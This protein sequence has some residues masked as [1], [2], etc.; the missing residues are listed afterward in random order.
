MTI[1]IGQD[2]SAFV[3]P[4]HAQVFAQAAEEFNCH[5]LVRE[6]GR[7]A[8][9]WIQRNGYT[10]KIADMKANTAD[11]NPHPYTLAGLVCCPLLVPQAFSPK[12][13]IRAQENW[14]KSA[15]L[16]TV[17]TD[18]AGF[19]DKRAPSRCKTPYLVQT[20]PRHKHYGAV[21]RV[22]MG[23]L[24]PRYVHG[25]YD[26]YAIVPAG[27]RFDPARVRTKESQLGISMN[28]HKMTFGQ[29]VAEEPR[30]MVKNIEGPLSYRVAM[31]INVT[32]AQHSGADAMNGLLVNHGEQALF[33]PTDEPVM[34]FMPQ[35][36]NGK[37]IATLRNMAEIND[38]YQNA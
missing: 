22:D 31:Y 12:R 3:H 11:L 10:G 32:I 5:I 8:T 2:V 27:K 9:G 35:A 26:L 17:P 6:T 14:V 30:H 37:R 23:L 15:H 13:L 25:D 18:K 7:A 21:A 4:Q 38:F 34:A 19:D 36:L 24:I 16:I 29:R 20:K 28:T 33:K 1:S